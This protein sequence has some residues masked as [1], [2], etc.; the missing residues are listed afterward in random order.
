MLSYILPNADSQKS[1]LV[2]QEFVVNSHKGNP[3]LGMVIFV[4]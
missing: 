1:E 3:Q 4:R 2:V